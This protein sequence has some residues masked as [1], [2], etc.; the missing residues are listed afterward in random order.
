MQNVKNVTESLP[1][2]KLSG[3][4]MLREL[5]IGPAQLRIYIIDGRLKAEKVRGKYYAT[6]EDFND[7]KNR[8]GF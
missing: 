1:T 4:E 3:N 6:R 5:P 2:S 8:L 7:F